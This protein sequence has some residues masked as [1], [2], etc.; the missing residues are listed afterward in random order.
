MPAPSFVP[1]T[2]LVEGSMPQLDVWVNPERIAYTQAHHTHR[3]DNRT[4]SVIGTRIFFAEDGVPDVLELP[5]T[6]LAL[7]DGK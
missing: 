6:V 5:Q 7:L 2:A 4:P 3:G 1:L